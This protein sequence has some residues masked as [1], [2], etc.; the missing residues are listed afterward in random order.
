[1]AS[2]KLISMVLLLAILVNPVSAQD[3]CLTSKESNMMNSLADNTNYSESEWT[4]LFT[5]ACERDQTYREIINDDVEEEMSDFKQEVSNNQTQFEE[6]ILDNK[7]PSLREN[8]TET[9]DN[10]LES[11]KNQITRLNEFADAL[12]RMSRQ[13][14]VSEDMK[15]KVSDLEENVSKNSQRISENEDDIFGSDQT[16]NLIDKEFTDRQNRNVATGGFMGGFNSKFWILILGLG[17][18]IGGFFFFRSEKGERFVD[19]VMQNDQET[20][21]SPAEEMDDG[22]VQD[23]EDMLD[24]AEDEE[25]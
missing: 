10:E 3:N 8:V 15:T 2:H 13:I 4:N 22:D 7:L 21:R 11:M 20:K 1:M 5:K 25:E 18:S 14:N 6:H 19:F 12:D 23:F 16:E 9:M 24:D 17:G